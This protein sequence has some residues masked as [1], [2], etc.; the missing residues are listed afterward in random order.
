V[1]AN[2]PLA[3]AAAKHAIDEGFALDL[4]SGIQVERRHYETVLKSE[5]RLEALRAFAERRPP[6]FQG[7]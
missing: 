3:I 2:G 6:S 1:A 7:R 5:D 4:D